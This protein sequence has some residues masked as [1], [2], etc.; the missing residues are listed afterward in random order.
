MSKKRRKNFSLSNEE[1]IE[2]NHTKLKCPNVLPGLANP[3]VKSLVQ[4]NK[5]TFH[6]RLRNTNNTTKPFQ[7]VVSNTISG[8]NI[9]MDSSASCEIAFPEKRN[10]ELNMSD[11][12]NE[13]FTIHFCT[14]KS[15]ET[16]NLI[17]QAQPN[18]SLY[19]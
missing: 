9:I 1:H 14:A 3:L 10:Q 16:D 2:D 7:A 8:E 5:L 13:D 4:P 17:D 6:P 15:P 11:E 19:S 18:F 12:E